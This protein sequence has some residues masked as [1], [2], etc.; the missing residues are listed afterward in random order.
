MKPVRG[1]G[2]AGSGGAMGKLADAEVV[3]VTS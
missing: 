3:A 2:E 1:S